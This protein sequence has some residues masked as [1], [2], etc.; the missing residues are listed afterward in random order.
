[1]H[2]VWALGAP[3]Y[4]LRRSQWVQGE[5]SQVFAFF[6]EP[7]NLSRITPPWLNFAIRSMTT[8]SI[9]AGSIIT[10]R[11]AWMGIPMRWVTLIEEWE[12]GKRFV[13]TALVSPYIRWRHE[14]T[15]TARSGGVMLEG[16]V[17]YRLPFGPIGAAAHALIVRRQL[18]AIFDYRA[19]VT[20]D[21]MSGGALMREPPTGARTP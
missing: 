13:D 6:E 1:M 15:F 7:R 3:T 14:H 16:T 2:P 4:Y 18:N 19:R 21:L 17:E 9:E 12:P 8:P 5:L 20:A 11:V 10:Y